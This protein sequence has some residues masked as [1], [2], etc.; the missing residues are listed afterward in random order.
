MFLNFAC[1]AKDY[2]K[3]AEQKIDWVGKIENYF[4][5]ELNSVQSDFTQIGS[6][7]NISTGKIFLKRKKGLMKIFDFINCKD[8]IEKLK[9]EA[10]PNGH[11][12]LISYKEF[13]EEIVKHNADFTLD[14]E[15]E[16]VKAGLT[17]EQCKNICENLNV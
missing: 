13:L 15:L 2:Q 9:N 7:G 4:N 12:A 8:N 6:R 5:S 16:T 1:C 14:T 3:L 17:L 11:E 10:G